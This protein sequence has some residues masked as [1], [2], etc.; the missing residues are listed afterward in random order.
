MPVV[1]AFNYGSGEYGNCIY[2]GEVGDNAFSFNVNTSTVTLS[3][4]VSTAASS[5]GTA[6][7]DVELNCSNFGYAVTI[8]GGSLTNGSHT[9]T[10]LTSPTASAAGTEQYGINLVANSSPSVGADPSGGSGVAASGYDTTNQFKYVSGNTIASTPSY[11]P[12]TTFTIS[13]IA[14]AS[15]TT[16]ATNYSTTHT[17]IC[18][19]TF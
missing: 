16:P 1:E 4:N 2:G 18:T 10:N 11:S 12:A 19:P 5:V 15:I 13:F 9:F 8:T 6:T 7:F 17:L 14:N 3:P